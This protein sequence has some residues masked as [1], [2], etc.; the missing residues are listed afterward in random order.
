[1]AAGSLG[2]ARYLK[3][4][5]GFELKYLWR[6]WSLGA[7]RYLKV[8][9]KVSACGGLN[10]RIKNIVWGPRAGIILLN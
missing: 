7:A 2:A 10:Y 5:E 3:V 8:P 9:K 1:M 4:S 6:P